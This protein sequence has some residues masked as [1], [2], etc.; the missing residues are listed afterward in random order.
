MDLL[1]VLDPAH[2]DDWYLLVGNDNDFI[3]KHCV[4]E[5]QACD[6]PIDNDNRI[7]VYRLTLPGMRSTTAPHH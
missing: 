5:G 1:P 6:S 2:P 7:L 4:M 3:A